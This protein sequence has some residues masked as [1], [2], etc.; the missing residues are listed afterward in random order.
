MKLPKATHEGKIG[1]VDCY[2]LDD[3]RFVLSRTMLQSAL[4]GGSPGA[5][6]FDRQIQRLSS[7][8]ST[9]QAP[10]TIEF[11]TLSGQTAKGI[12]DEALAEICQAYTDSLVNG[13]I[14]TKTLPVAQRA[15]ELQKSWAKIGLR[16]AILIATG[17][18]PKTV[19]EE[20]RSFIERVLRS[21]PRDY[22]VVYDVEFTDAIRRLYGHPRRVGDSKRQPRFMASVYG[23][24]YRKFL[25]TDIA[26]I[27]KER[28]PYPSSNTSLHHQWLVDEVLRELQSIRSAI[29]YIAG[30]SGR[31]VTYFWEQIDELLG[32]G[33]QRLLP[34]A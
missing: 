13:T 23:K 34:A 25:G 31:S 1:S 6:D 5:K 32:I 7:K 30:R 10:P 21:A 4:S 3:G 26:K 17:I 14:H 2:V 12:D 27:I 18:K 11:V 24:F 29:I 28:N 9:F 16:T 20:A 33:R 22:S 19:V 15:Y 8:I